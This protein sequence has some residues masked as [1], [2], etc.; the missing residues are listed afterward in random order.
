MHMGTSIQ[1]LYLGVVHKLQTLVIQNMLIGE[2]WDMSRIYIPLQ[3][4]PQ[5]PTCLPVIT[6]LHMD[7]PYTR[8]HTSNP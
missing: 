8:G 4:C 2:S 6:Y 7:L 5:H 3:G 1:I